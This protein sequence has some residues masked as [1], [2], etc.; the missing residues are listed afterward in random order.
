MHA[1]GFE[2]KRV[3]QRSLVYARAFARGF[4][5]GVTP[6]RLDMLAAVFQ[7]HVLIQRQ[8][9][10]V[11]GVCEMTVS[12]MVRALEKLG[13]VH[14][15]KSEFDARERFVFLTRRGFDLVK[16]FLARDVASGLTSFPLVEALHEP[17]SWG[18]DACHAD[19]D[20]RLREDSPASRAGCAVARRVAARLERLRNLLCSVRRR[21]R[22]FAGL[23]YD[24]VVARRNEEYEDPRSEPDV[25]PGG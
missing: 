11:L 3:Y 6:A 13:L 8:L 24:D 19:L 21:W 23:R 12:R 10:E 2:I 15:E 25:T 7:E 16:E 18:C 4:G 17:P 9:A 5:R 20:E 1:L 14:R 22:D